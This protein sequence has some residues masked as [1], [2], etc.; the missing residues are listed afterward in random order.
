[1][2]ESSQPGTGEY[3]RPAGAAPGWARLGEV[4]RG[5]DW[6]LRTETY[7]LTAGRG[8]E[9]WLQEGAADDPLF[10]LLHLGA[11]SV[12]PPPELAAALAASGLLADRDDA[13]QA[14]THRTKDHYFTAF[15]GLLTV[16]DRHDRPARSGVYLGE[17]GLTFT[18]RL[19]SVHAG[20][21]ALDIGSGSG[22]TTSALAA[23]GLHTTAIDIS[24]ACVAATAATAALN[25]LAHRVE[26]VTA[27]A[28]A[29]LEGSGRYDF[30]ASNP[31]GVVVP[32][33]LAYGPGGNGGP[34]GLDVVRAVTANAPRMLRDGGVL[35]MRFESAGDERG[36]AALA[37]IFDHAGDSSVLV[38]VQASLP[39]RTRSGLTALRAAAHNPGL[40]AAELLRRLD[41]HTDAL[42]ACRFYTSFLLLRRDG[43]A[44]REVR[45]LSGVLPG[46]TRGGANRPEPPA[47][48][49]SRLPPGVAGLDWEGHL[50]L[51]RERWDEA[52]LAAR[53]H[54]D[55]DAVVA[56]VFGDAVERDPVHSRSLHA[57]LSA[58]PGMP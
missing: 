31:P 36:P 55:P 43:R 21:T 5:L 17:D 39:M 2:K 19:L 24:P 37:E 47:E 15:R 23:R 56:E 35:L 12:A 1:M 22:L 32:D 30:I 40:S 38:T 51:V 29:A 46:R 52:V 25:G 54:G 33:S 6:A 28:T 57:F 34:D 3:G 11:S 42:G 18:D 13:E 27:D 41:A 53:R 58:L 49:A 14:G 20:G 7:R 16:A 45:D 26:A 50:R 9:P 10:H 44:R 8:L 4:L 48:D